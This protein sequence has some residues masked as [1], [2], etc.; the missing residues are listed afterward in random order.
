MFAHQLTANSEAHQ[1]VHF[2]Q[3]QFA[4][5]ALVPNTH[6]C[7]LIHVQYHIVVEVNRRQMFRIPIT[8]MSRPARNG[9]DNYQVMYDVDKTGAGRARSAK[10][11][12]LLNIRI[13]AGQIDA[14][15]GKSIAS[16]VSVFQPVYPIYRPVKQWCDDAHE[17]DEAS[18]CTDDD[19]DV[20]DANANSL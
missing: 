15:T 16:G 7:S 12:Q 2:D 17:V 18:F 5:P 13:C 10:Q 3:L 19:D 4:V 8:I 20:K 1:L 9:A 14:S 6:G 11:Q